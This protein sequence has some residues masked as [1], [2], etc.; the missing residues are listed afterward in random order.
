MQQRLLRPASYQLVSNGP[1]SL[2]NLILLIPV[3]TPALGHG[4]WKALHVCL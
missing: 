3:R 4:Q 1:A 2:L